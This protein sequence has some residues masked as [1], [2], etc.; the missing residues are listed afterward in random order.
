MTRAS[1][2]YLG[3]CFTKPARASLRIIAEAVKWLRRAADQNDSS[4]QCY[5][6]CATRPGFGVPQEF[7]RGGAMVSSEAA[8]QGDPAA[9][10]N[11]GVCYETG[12]EV[13]SC[14]IT[15]RPSNGTTPPPSRASRRR[16]LIWSVFYETGQVVPRKLRRPAAEWYRRAA[17]QEV[18]PAQCN[19]GLCYQTGR[20]V[21]KSE[22]E[23]VEV[24]HPALP[25]A[26]AIKPPSTIWDFITPLWKRPRL[27]APPRRPA[28]APPPP[29]PP[30]K[31]TAPR[32]SHSQSRG[33]C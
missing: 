18:A 22:A 4:A 30:P 32:T 6:E 9:Q 20:G 2:C 11:L 15:P 17:E 29:P 33:E 25:P 23:A 19:L 7:A 16:N 12:A 24:V 8:E 1:Q 26:R 21:D 31:E 3:I 27:S 10:F 14:R 28:A 13:A 5:L